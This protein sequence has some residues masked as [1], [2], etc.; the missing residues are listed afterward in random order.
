MA[1]PASAQQQYNVYPPGSN[2]PSVIVDLSVLEKLGPKPSLPGMLRPDRLQLAPSPQGVLLPPPIKPPRSRLT[3]PKGFIKRGGTATPQAAVQT[4]PTPA[5]AA[6][7]RHPVPTAPSIAKPPVPS[8]NVSATRKPAMGALPP[9][10][11]IQSARKIPKAP[12]TK[13]TTAQ[14]KPPAQNVRR[15]VVPPPPKMANLARTAPRPAAPR[16][17]AVPPPPVVARATPP[18]VPPIL[19]P[20]PKSNSQT[21]PKVSVPQPPKMAP[22]PN[23][24]SAETAQTRTT[25]DGTIRIGFGKSSSDLPNSATGAL[26]KLARQMSG[27]T[28]LRVQLHGYSNGASASPSQARRLSLFRALSVRTYLMKKGVRSTRIDVR[29]LGKK[30]D[31]EAANRVDVI[32][33]KS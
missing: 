33:Q 10:A 16:P 32:I 24:V 30:A 29:A 6:I 8:S 4:P 7:R 26:D 14:P 18:A 25:T 15:S 27:N 31:G 17:T 19:T 5:I 1:T 12:P 11:P 20:P 2:R 28:D 23:L 9:P 22:K 21:I 3:L 13:Q